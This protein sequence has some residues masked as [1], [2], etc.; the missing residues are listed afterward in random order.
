MLKRIKKKY[1]NL[2]PYKF[3]YYFYTR[4]MVKHH[5]INLLNC[6]GIYALC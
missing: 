2:K 6:F 5:I 4:E 3:Y 1:S